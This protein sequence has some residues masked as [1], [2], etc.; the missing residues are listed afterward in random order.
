MV[1]KVE[2]NRDKE[3]D[4][5][6]R[7]E[8]FL[9]YYLDPQSETF[10]VISKSAIRAGYSET[11]ANNLTGLLPKWFSDNVYDH[12]LVKTAEGNLKGY[13]EMKGTKKVSLDGVTVIEVDDPS[14]HKIKADMT[15]F[16]LERLNKEKY[17]QRSE[18]TGKDGSDLP[19]IALVNFIDEPNIS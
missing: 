3:Y 15:K 17:S 9:S 8:L 2:K 6:P 18:L 1:K 7:Q 19:P 13:L 16:T 5:S 10:S 11:F 12:Y 4:L 14:M